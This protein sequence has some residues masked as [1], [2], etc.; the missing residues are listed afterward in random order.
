MQKTV[1]SSAALP[2]AHV[3]LRI[4]IV[5][6]WITAAAIV[7]LLVAMPNRDWIMAAFKLAPSPDADRVIW[8]LRVV[9]TLGIVVV[10]LN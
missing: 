6:N 2:I 8:G 4:L 10:L 3:G 9:A 7:V 1:P 5:L